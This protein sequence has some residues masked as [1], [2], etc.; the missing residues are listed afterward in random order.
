M[1][2]YGAW[3]FSKRAGHQLADWLASTGA[4]KHP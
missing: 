4:L 1:N 3:T 2:T